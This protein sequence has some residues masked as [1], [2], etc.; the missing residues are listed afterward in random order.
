MTQ[1][2]Q[3]I[4]TDIERIRT[5]APLVHNIT[6]FV[7]MNNTANA[8]LAL[9][10]SPAMVHAPDEVEEFVSISSA[11]VVNIGTLDATFVAGMKLAMR[12]AKTLG[13]PIV[14]D[15]VGVGATTFRNRVSEE[16]LALAPPDIIRGNA[17]EI[18]ALAGLN[19][20]TKGVD[21]LYGSEAAVDAAKRLSSVWG[22]VVVI[23]GATDY[24]IQGEQ[25]AVVANGHPLMTKVTGMGCTATALTGAFAA[26]NTNY[27]QA[28]THAMA[29]MGIAGELAAEKKLAPGSLQVNFLD[30]LYELTESEIDE[31]L[32]LTWA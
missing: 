32:K 5:Q 27:F 7:V 24:I 21:S 8:L 26:V 16:L 18:M 22:S 9:G 30:A 6:N 15:P 2:P 29:V 28:A 10:A 19:A 17:S 1:S 14:F 11:L 4:W 3:S 13:K 31:R 23:S 20:Q 25:T 12:Q